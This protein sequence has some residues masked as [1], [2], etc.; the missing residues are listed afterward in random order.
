MIKSDCHSRAG[1]NPAE[2][3]SGI[4]GKTVVWSRSECDDSIS[5]MP[6]SLDPRMGWSR[7]G[8]TLSE[9]SGL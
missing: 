4:A 1:G 7:A 3:M 5:C 6:A 8:M 9:V 2:K